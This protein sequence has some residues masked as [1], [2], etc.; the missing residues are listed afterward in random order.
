MTC[1]IL[2]RSFDH[3]V[4]LSAVYLQPQAFGLRPLISKT[5][6]FYDRFMKRD[7]SVRNSVANIFVK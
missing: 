7:G 1:P 6:I 4:L 2:L 5:A 3:N